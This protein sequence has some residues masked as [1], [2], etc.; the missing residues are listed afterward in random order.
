MERKDFL[1]NSIGIFGLTSIIPVFNAC[2]KDSVTEAA[3][4][5]GTSA[6]RCVV[7]DTET[8]GPYLLYNN[9]GSSVQRVDI[10][11]GKTG[12]PLS[13]VITIRNV[14]NNCAVLPNARVDIW[15]CDKDDYY[16][17]Y[18]NSGYLGMQNNSSA[19]FC[20]AYNM[21]IPTGR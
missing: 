10:A 4:D 18:T 17:G 19:V 5:T 13:M 9:R 2:K 1:K 12:V 3:A 6:G 11:D 16:S 8:D 21:P 14:N 15:H 7:T 20:R